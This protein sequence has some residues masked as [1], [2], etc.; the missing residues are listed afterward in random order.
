M[1]YMLRLA[2]ELLVARR[3]ADE[4]RAFMFSLLGDEHRTG[5]GTRLKSTPCDQAAASTA[6]T[7]G[8]N[9]SHPLV[10]RKWADLMDDDSDGT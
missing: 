8:S 1:T 5:D 3:G 2:I 4:T 6:A 9:V 7:S 10:R